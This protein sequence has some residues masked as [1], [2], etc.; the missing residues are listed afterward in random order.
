MF[1]VTKVRTTSS[2]VTVFLLFP[3]L[4]KSR[5]PVQSVL[6]ALFFVTE[7]RTTVPSV[8]VFCFSFLFLFCLFVFGF[9]QSFLRYRITHAH[10]FK[11]FAET[12]TSHAPRDCDHDR[13]C[14]TLCPVLRL[15]LHVLT[16][17]PS[18]P[19]VMALT[20]RW[21]LQL[22]KTNTRQTPKEKLRQQQH[23]VDGATLRTLAYPVNGRH[24][25]S[26]PYDVTSSS[27]LSLSWF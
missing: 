13:K 2:S 27:S 1:F 25:T 11:A 6:T 15:P 26:C 20:H 22:R 10:Q 21:T 8:A 3:S 12:C 18:V 17:K 7:V 23:C 4:L 16:S 5:P 9:L 14:S 19:P 24:M